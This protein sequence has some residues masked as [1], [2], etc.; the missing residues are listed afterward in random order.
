M[1]RLSLV[2][3]PM[4][5]L[6]LVSEW[7]WTRSIFYIT[8][9][10]T[11]SSAS[12]LINFPKII[13][14][15]HGKS[16]SFEDLEDEHAVDII[17]KKRFQR[18]FEITITIALAVL[19]AVLIDY[20]L[21]RFQK[22][23]LSNLEILGVVG[24]FM[25]LLYKIEDFIGKLLLVGLH[26]YKRVCTPRSLSGDKSS[27]SS[28]DIPPLTISEPIYPSHISSQFYPQYETQTLDFTTC[29]DL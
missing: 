6:V 14:L 2:F 25:S 7:E 20:Y 12:I 1:K 3:L 23:E 17:M 13:H 19:M 15:L 26:R 16:V 8:P 4:P 11:L 24:G 18:T 22:T 9:A 21:D 28:I 5:I 27:L 29:Q 10:V